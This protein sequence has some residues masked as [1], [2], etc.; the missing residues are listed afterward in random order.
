LSEKIVGVKKLLESNILFL[1]KFCTNTLHHGG[2]GAAGG[3]DRL[4]DLVRVEHLIRLPGLGAHGVA[5]L[6]SE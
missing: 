6:P 2:D 5:R 3:L 4:D 1:E